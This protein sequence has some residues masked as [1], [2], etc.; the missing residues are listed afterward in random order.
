MILGPA[1]ASKAD[2]KTKMDG[3]VAPSRSKRAADEDGEDAKREEEDC[4]LTSP[5][6]MWW[7]HLEQVA[8][9]CNLWQ[10]K[11]L[12]QAQAKVHLDAMDLEGE[13]IMWM[14]EKLAERHRKLGEIINEAVD[15]KGD[16]ESAAQV[17][18][19]VEVGVGGREGEGCV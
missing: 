2:K 4:F 14:R 9:F 6:V 5:H 17:L 19:D 10:R 3:A 1:S 13:S 15:A 7:L 18:S 11:L 12:T 8:I 16:K